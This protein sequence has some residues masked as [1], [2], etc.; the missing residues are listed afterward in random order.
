M[1]IQN[2]DDGANLT[3]PIVLPRIEQGKI[4]RTCGGTGKLQLKTSKGIEKIF[5][6]CCNGRGYG[7]ATK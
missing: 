4:C 5:C 1:S 6:P 2:A 7:Y 3:P